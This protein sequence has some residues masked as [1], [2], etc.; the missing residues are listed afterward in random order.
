MATEEERKEL[1]QVL[2]GIIE[3]TNELATMEETK[4][5]LENEVI[6]TIDQAVKNKTA[7]IPEVIEAWN[8]AKKFL[9]ASKN[10]KIYLAKAYQ[11][12]LEYLIVK[13]VEKDIKVPYAEDY[14]T[15]ISKL[16]EKSRAIAEGKEEIEPKEEVESMPAELQIAKFINDKI[17]ELEKLE[18][19]KVNADEVL[20]AEIIQ[21][22]E[23]KSDYRSDKDMLT[24]AKVLLETISK[25]SNE[26]KI[27][28][29][30]AHQKRLEI[31]IFE[32]FGEVHAV[33]G[34]KLGKKFEG[35]VFNIDDYERHL[36]EMDDVEKEL[37]DAVEDIKKA[38]V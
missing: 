4:I 3:D 24:E 30:K 34:Q 38:V 35:R 28:T 6:K 21:N 8:S 11:K 32:A 25:V 22:L 7:M 26:R 20:M 9:Q 37:V 12:K 5:R 31:I 17:K 36:R 15:L 23:G 16:D 13:M 29:A 14:I 33:G 18:Q 2:R 27:Y 10:S 19:W 1:L